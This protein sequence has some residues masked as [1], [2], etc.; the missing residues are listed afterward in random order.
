MF[1]MTMNK[2]NWFLHGVKD[3][4]LKRGLKTEEDRTR[5]IK[6]L[7]RSFIAAFIYSIFYGIY[8]YFVVYTHWKWVNIIGVELNWLI[9]YT[10]LILTVLIASRLSIEN[11][12]MGLFLMS[13][14][15]DIIYWMCQ[16]V[17]TG[18]YPYPAPNWWDSTLASYQA[19]GGLG[20]PIP[21]W[22]YVP[23]YYIPGF[24]LISLFYISSY[25][26]AKPGRI[27]TWLVG[28]FFL[29]IIAGALGN[30]G[31][32]RIIL[33]ALPLISYAYILTLYKFRNRIF[34]KEI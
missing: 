24:I 32:A 6:V 23:F 16:W 27:Y 26:G 20:W 12:I 14:V 8:E 11:T 4:F 31:M 29:A 30:I 28:P 10:G 17:D 18:I 1:R 7:R 25:I 22:P 2:S 21:F 34:G 13:V 33:I 3:L 5:H 19:L 15:E 9:M